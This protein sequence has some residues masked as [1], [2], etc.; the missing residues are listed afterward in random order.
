MADI[1]GYLKVRKIRTYSEL[2]QLD[3]YEDRLEYLKVPGAVG[4]N[5]FGFDRYLNQR[6]YK[7]KEW[8]KIRNDIFVRDNGCDLAF[9]D[10]PIFG[11]Y[12]IHHM[13]PIQVD[14]IVKLSDYLMNPEYLITVTH[15]THNAIHYGSDIPIIKPSQRTSNDTLLW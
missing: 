1:L 13:N 8:R 9:E 14:D 3:S 4:A 12:L 10:C 7:S 15:Q 6:F 11:A 2:I 5:T